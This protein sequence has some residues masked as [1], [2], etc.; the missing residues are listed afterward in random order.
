[1]GSGDEYHFSTW[2]ELLIIN[3]LGCFEDL[4][5]GRHPALSLQHNYALIRRHHVFIN[6]L[7]WVINDHSIMVSLRPI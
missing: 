7:T 1:M 3:L 5:L 4:I 6:H 2:Q